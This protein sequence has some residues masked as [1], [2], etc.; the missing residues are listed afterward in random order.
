MQTNYRSFLLTV[1]SVTFTSFAVQTASAAPDADLMQ[2][3]QARTLGPAAMSGRISTIDVVASDPNRIIVGAGTGGVWMSENGGLNWEPVF[4]DQPVASIGAIAINQA[5]P[6]I[7]WVGTGESN[8]RN[9]TSIGGGIYKSVD[10][11]ETWALSGLANSERIDRIALHPTDSN[12]VYVAA[13]GT[14]WGPNEERGIYKTTD[15]GATWNHILYVDQLTGATDIKMDPSN[16][17]K[18]Y[19]GMWQFR[20]WPYQFKSGGPGSG[21][22]VSDDAGKT[23][24]RR[25]E[26]DGL[27]EGE[28][29]RMVFGLSAADPKRVYALVEADSSALLVSNNGGQDWEAVN[30]EYNVADRPFYYTEIAVD[31]ND[32][33]HVYNIATNIRCIDRWRKDFR[34]KPGR[35]LL[36]RQQHDSYRQSRLLDQS[37]RFES[38]DRRQ[39]WRDRDHPRPR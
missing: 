22:Y 3:L 17:D 20:R 2:G 6:D 14:L 9:S 11:G 21:M 16:P 24:E 28:L 29:G 8:V 27:P 4:D 36:C 23:W 15:G 12:I 39:R 13:M 26:E 25:T 7:I 37:P 10:G 32:A 34:T 38:P 30:E 19:A 35:C 1:I 18:L 33:N 5:N 31:P